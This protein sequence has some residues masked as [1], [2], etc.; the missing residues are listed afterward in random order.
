VHER[1]VPSA[2]TGRSSP[3][4]LV[5]VFACG[6]YRPNQSNSSVGVDLALAM[7]TPT[8][9]ARCACYRILASCRDGSWVQD[10][11]GLSS[12]PVGVPAMVDI[13]YV[14]EL[15][16]LLDAI[17]HPV[18]TGVGLSIG[19]RKACAAEFLLVLGSRP[20]GRR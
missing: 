14:D 15:I 10:R 16:G 8:L 12:A 3:K 2:C 1:S 6:P 7:D 18:F 19:L 11:L 5:D 9:M 13:E 17:A 20:T 4:V